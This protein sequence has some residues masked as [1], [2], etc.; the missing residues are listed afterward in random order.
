MGGK[1][2]RAGDAREE[3]AYCGFP[4]VAAEQAAVL[5]SVIDEQGGKPV[6]IVAAITQVTVDRLHRTDLLDRFEPGDAL[7]KGQ[8]AHLAAPLDVARDAS[9]MPSTPALL[10]QAGCSADALS[11]MVNLGDPRGG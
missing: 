1:D 4:L 5:D 3:I 8:V 2:Q 7:F 10:R 6:G 11:P 9:D